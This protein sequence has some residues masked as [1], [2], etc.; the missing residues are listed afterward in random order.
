VEVAVRHGIRRGW[1]RPGVWRRLPASQ[2]SVQVQF[3]DGTRFT[4]RA[5]RANA[6]ARELW[7]LNLEGPE[8]HSLRAFHDLAST[9][10]LVVDIGSHTGLYTL[11]ALSASPRVHV[12]AFEPVQ[13]NREEFV[14]NL[15]DNGWRNRCII[16]PQAVGDVSRRA[17]LHVPYGDL[18]T[19]AS[20]APN[21]FRNLAGRLID[22]DIV[23]VDEALGDLM[24]TL[25]KIDVEGFEPEVLRGM[26]T[27]LGRC[28]PYLI[29]EA[30]PDGPNIEVQDLL[31]SFG[32]EFE[33]LMPGPVKRQIT[34]PIDVTETYRN[35]LCVPPQ[36]SD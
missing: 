2:P 31:R 8:G 24:P 27:I 12:I 35:V 9:A 25:V 13:G 5:Q 18:P 16:H 32:Y 1:V 29:V 20:L 3:S 15:A 11:G 33:A 34:L 30:N 36:S 17:H 6:I 23:T 28:L 10:D 19:S 4:Y 22:V 21:G 26:A 14:H 7:W